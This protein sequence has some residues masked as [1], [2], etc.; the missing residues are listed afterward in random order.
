MSLMSFTACKVLLPNL[1][2]C[3]EDGA[4]LV[5]QEVADDMVIAVL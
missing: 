5:A 2:S 4:T 3:S 1:N